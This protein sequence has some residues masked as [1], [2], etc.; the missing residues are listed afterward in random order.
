MVKNKSLSGI[1]STTF[2]AGLVA[3]ILVSSS[4][5]TVIATQ[6][7]RGPQGEQ[8]PQGIQGIQGPKG[9]KGDTG[10]QGPAGAD[11]ATGPQGP[12]GEQG[13]IGPEGPQGPPGLYTPEY[14]SGW[15]DISNMAGQYLNISHNLNST[16]IFVDIQGKTTTGGGIHQKYLGL[17]GYELGW[18]RTYGEGN[19]MEANSL[20]QTS[21]GG[22]ALAGGT[23]SPWT[24]R[25]IKT[26]A[27]GNVQWSKTYAREGGAVCR[28]V[29]QTRDGG[30]A[31]AGWT[32]SYSS[33]SWDFWLVK[34]DSNGNMQWNMA[35]GGTLNDGANSLVQ[36]SDGGYALVGETESFGSGQS[37]VPDFW[38]IKTNSTG[39]MQWSRTYGGMNG[40]YAPSVVQTSDEGYALAGYTYSYGAKGD[41]WLVKTD[42]TGNIQ[43]NKTYGGANSDEV[44]SIVKTRD[45]GY[46]L[47]GFS[48]SFGWGFWLVKT[49]SNGVTEWDRTYRAIDYAEARSVIQTSDNGYAMAGYKWIHGGESD[50]WLVKT[51]SNGNMQWNMTFGGAGEDVA[52]SV[53]QATDGGYAILGG[54]DSFG[55]VGDLIFDFWL[56]KTNAESGLAWTD[57]TVDTITLYRG[58]TDPYWN[59]VRIRVWKISEP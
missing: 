27:T 6:W 43:W 44:H 20:V 37:S 51:D 46:A 24:F 3:A 49:D 50:F 13:P 18:S 23:A 17:T 45:G 5:S 35:Y 10:E 48:I 7:A 8:G 30:Y 58:A 16:D 52:T 26:D 59:Y 21:D 19:Q 4:L 22:Y 1:S 33:S 56:V 53:V 40:E 41:A 54:T 29:V 15:V 47:A 14:D 55:T 31:L 36:T 39:S 38:L 9:D 28:S 11:G 12:Q 25:L 32:Y 34:T 42:S 2:I 57:S